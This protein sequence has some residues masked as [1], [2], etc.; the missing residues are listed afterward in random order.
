MRSLLFATLLAVGL[1][2]AVGRS[3]FAG[4]DQSPFIDLAW[5]LANGFWS[6]R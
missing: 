5:R 4:Y 2:E 1:N 6:P 3:Q